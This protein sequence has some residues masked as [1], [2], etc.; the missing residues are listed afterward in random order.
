M[1]AP[2]LSTAT[3]LW[4]GL[5]QLSHG[6]KEEGFT[7][8]LL[9]YYTQVIGL[10]GTL[11]GQ[12]IL[13]ALVFDAVTDPVLGVVSDRLDTRWGRRHPLIYA[14][15]LPVSLSFFCV[16]VPPAGLGPTGIFVWLV[17][18]TVLCRVSITLF[19]V[20]HMALG[21]ELSDDYGMRTSVVGTRYFFD[22]TG[23]FLAGGLGLLVFMRPTSEFPDGQLNGAAYP[24]FA[25]VCA[26]LIFLS[27][28]LS[29]W[30]THSRIPFLPRRDPSA[31]ELGVVATVLR[32]MR[33]AL[34]HRSFRS[35]FFGNTVTF[36]A[37][38]LTGALGLHLGT[39]FW[40]ATTDQLFVWGFCA[41]IGIYLGLPFWTRVA[42]TRDKKHVF[43]LGQAIFVAFTATPPLLRI[44]GLWP[45]LG[46]AAYIPA[47][48]LTTGTA[49]HFGIAS[50]MV[51]GGS[52][53][54]DVT[55]E[56]A[57]RHGRRRQG[58]FFGSLSFAAKASFGI[59][60]LLAG[61]VVDSVALEP[62]LASTEVPPH[63]VRD[64]GLTL[65]VSIAVLVGLSLAIFA[66]Y[67]LS[68]E[69]HAEVQA[70]LRALDER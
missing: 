18:F 63:V 36:V 62:G 56:D 26:V 3:R 27:I 21:A 48:V 15:A 23:H 14:S 22:R 6:M 13:I 53:M 20:P 61:L 33:E 30:G 57:L 32:D 50:T 64:L 41:G 44:L 28:V 46:S 16:F 8:F 60:G 65:C 43:M 5:G 42:Q 35:L 10:S 45:E 69:R 34:G 66:R 25:A 70:A 51:T 31:E 11:A 2:P 9:F 58:I 4:Y 55:D 37:W 54:A 39:Y 12:A 17:T 7:L 52:M 67:D 29:G 47:F 1:A 40:Q 38:G 59:G 49:A 24:P 68:R 19:F